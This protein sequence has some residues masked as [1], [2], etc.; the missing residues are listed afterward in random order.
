MRPEA[1]H[2]ITHLAQ[3][4]SQDDEEAHQISRVA[5]KDALGIVPAHVLGSS[6]HGRRNDFAGCVHQ[7]FCEPFEDLLDDLWVWLLQ[8]RDTELDADVR[9]ATCDLVVGLWAC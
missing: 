6:A 9:N 7:Q 4:L 2:F 1:E 5:C 3:K 8:I